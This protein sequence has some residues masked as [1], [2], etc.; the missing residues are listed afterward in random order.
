MG[1]VDQ[2]VAGLAVSLAPVVL[3]HGADR[4]PVRVPE[5][6]TWAQL[7]RDRE[8]VQLAAELAVVAQ[9]GLLQPLQVLLQLRTRVPG[10]AVNPLQHGLGFVAMPVGAGGMGQL[11]GGDLPG[12]TNMR[13]TAEVEEVACAVAA[14]HLAI[15]DPLDQLDLE[16]LA[17]APK[18][19][20]RLLAAHLLAQVFRRA[21]GNLVHPRLD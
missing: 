1:A 5:D 3:D 2:L 6:Q 12:V 21:A 18:L 7:L 13:A 11:E 20:Q 9:R 17:P 15:G 14:D 16:A 4:G 8:E 10:G 19:C